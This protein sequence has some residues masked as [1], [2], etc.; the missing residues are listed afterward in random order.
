V[1]NIRAA[2]LRRKGGPL[3]VEPL[4][5][6]GPR[7]EEVLVR[8]V[9]SG[10]CHTDIDFIDDWDGPPAVLGHEGAGV[11]EQVGRGVKGLRRGDHV[12]LSYQSCGRCRRCRSG[13][14]AH[15]ERFWEAN[16]GFGRLD[17]SNALGRSGVRG[18]FFGQSSF[19]THA[20]PTKRNIVKVPGDL[21]LGLLAPLGCGLQ[22]GAGTVMNSLKV[23]A[24]EGV[25]VFGTGAVGLAAVMAALIVGADPIIGVDINPRRLKLALQ[26]GATHA[27][28]SRREDLASRIAGITGRG[29]HYVLETTGDPAMR[30]LAAGVLKPRGKVA[31]IAAP[32]GAESLPEGRKAIGII[33]GDSVP[34][35]FIPKLIGL[36]RAGRFPFHRLVRFYDFSEINR[37]VADARRGLAIKP[38][39]R[40]GRTRVKA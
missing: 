33:Q 36:Y 22:T 34:Q 32:E 40:I 23:R 14:P 21:P 2:V 27:I 19:A 39:L 18:H 16:F 17:G 29:V 13:R 12:V 11:V 9:A 24:G 8:I 6:E 37:A 31:L 28:D 10:I 20:L 3:R 7:P 5:L 30:R 25:A 1:H 26:L 4:E 35:L 38:V 15:C